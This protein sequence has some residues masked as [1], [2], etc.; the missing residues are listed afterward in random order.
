MRMRS[1]K[2]K[3]RFNSPINIQPQLQSRPFD[4]K[5]HSANQT[6]DLQ[7]QP[8]L[9]KVLPVGSTASSPLKGIKSSVT[10]TSNLNL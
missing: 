1:R 8:D 9:P 5:S 7:N 6:A 4:D 3:D 10:T 2:K